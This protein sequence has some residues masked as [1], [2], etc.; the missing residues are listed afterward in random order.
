MVLGIDIGSCYTKGILVDSAVIG[1]HLVKTSFKPKSAIAEVKKNLTGY[2]RIVATGYGRELVPDAD[3]VITEISALARG[4][5]YLNPAVRTVIDIGGQDSKIIKIRDRKIDRF[6][7]NDRCAAGTGNFVGK[8]G[9][10][11]GLTLEEFGRL[12]LKSDRPEPIDS[13]CVV[14]A[15]TEILSLVS[16]EKKLEDIVFGVCDSLIRRLIGLGSQIGIEEPVLFCG[17]GALNP[18]L[19]KALKRF[20]R[21]VTVPDDPQF[22]GALGAAVSSA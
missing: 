5:S 1:R 13:L 6:V 19:I 10:S 21:D 17:G 4:A 20:I 2:D 7:M 22:V 3:R 12:A 11:L 8:I 15:E 16:E 9:I 14:M 18:G